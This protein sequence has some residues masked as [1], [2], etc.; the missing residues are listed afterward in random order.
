MDPLTQGLVGAALPMATQRR[1]RVVIA[2]LCGFLGGLAPDLDIAISSSQDNLLFLEFHRHFTHALIFIP[3]GSAC[4]AACIFGFA[5]RHIKLGYMSI[6]MFCALGYATHGLLDTTTSYGT[7]LLWPFDNSRFALSLISIIDPLFTLPI[8]GFV[9]TGLICRNCYWARAALVWGALYLGAGAW[10]HHGAMAQARGLAASRDH[11]PERVTV[12]P[13][14]A[15]IFL[16]R[17]VYEVNGRFHVDAVRPWPSPRIIPGSVAPQLDISRDLPWLELES[18]QARDIER[19]RFFSQDFLVKGSDFRP[20]IFDVR[21][22]F[23]PTEIAALWYIRLDPYA[24]NFAHAVYETER[25][26]SLE[27]LADLVDMVFSESQPNLKPA[28][29]NREPCLGCR[30]SSD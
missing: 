24:D 13:S 12:K 9:L 17:S 26:H 8:L 1:P 28:A 2:A 21:F 7:H 22:A 20:N 23:L 6:W 18:Q 16:W 5:R 27:L 30:G 25:S 10:Q 14:F 11:I 19:F 29:L 15:N 4:V 3:V